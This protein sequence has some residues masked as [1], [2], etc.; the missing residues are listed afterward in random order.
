MSQADIDAF[1]DAFVDSA[2]WFGT[3]TPK[4]VIA[5][6]EKGIPVSGRHRKRNV[7]ALHYAVFYQRRELVV[8][9]LAVGADANAKNAFGETSVSWGAYESTADILQGRVIAS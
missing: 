7:T 2:G 4:G 3:L 8:S 9:L 1:V 6:V 5:S